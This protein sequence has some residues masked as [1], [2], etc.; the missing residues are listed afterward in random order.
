MPTRSPATST[1]RTAPSRAVVKKAALVGPDCALVL[2]AES[3]SALALSYWDLGVRP[4]G[5]RGLCRELG[6]LR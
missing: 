3:Q 2:S 5:R 1:A 4:S 6:A